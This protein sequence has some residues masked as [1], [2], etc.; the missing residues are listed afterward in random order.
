MG[1]RVVGYCRVST[2]NQTG[3]D[4]YG[5]RSQKKDIMEFCE[6]NGYD[7]IEWFIDEAVSGAKD[8]TDRPELRKILNGEFKE[9]PIYAV[10]VAKSDRLARD[11]EKY[12]GFKYLLKRNKIEVI[13]I[14][15]DF[16]SAGLY[17]PIYEAVTAVFAQMERQFINARMSGGR[18]IKAA[19]G[20]YAGG[21]PPFGYMVDKNEKN[22]VIN[23]KEAKVVKRIFELKYG[24][25]MT[26]PFR[27]AESLNEDGYR[28]RSGGVF[29]NSNV[30]RILDNENFYLGMCKYGK[31]SDW[32]PG[33]HKPIL[34]KGFLDSL[35]QG[36]S[37]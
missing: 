9:P 20:G 4:K 33:L 12:Y 8:D 16:G 22:L 30:K 18:A 37:E 28:C 1:M 3:E 34:T 26:S 29:Y 32:I 13:S 31:D 17:A 5:I 6:K 21:R 25:G 23:E 11:I 14:S 19:K 2:K 35:T 15:E 27:I 24:Y 7:I 10:V 36:Q